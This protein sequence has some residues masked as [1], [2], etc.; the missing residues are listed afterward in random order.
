MMLP[1]LPNVRIVL[2]PGEVATV[3]DRVPRTMRKALIFG[4]LI[5]LVVILVFIARGDKP[6]IFLVAE[7]VIY[8]MLAMSFNIQSGYA[9]L[10]NLAIG[11]IA[12][13]GAYVEAYT[14]T[15]LGYPFWIVLPLCGL[16][17]AAIERR[18]LPMPPDGTGRAAGQVKRKCNN[19]PVR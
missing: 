19:L 9:S 4:G 15:S 10:F 17:S 2:P 1:R 7:M 14:T 12:G 5:G 8:A 3:E 13:I 11:G 16:S 6:I 18:T